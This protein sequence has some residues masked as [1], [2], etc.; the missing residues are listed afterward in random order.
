[1]AARKRKPPVAS[2]STESRV[3][4]SFGG[5]SVARIQL[6]KRM[7]D[8][9]D[10]T[11]AADLWER[12]LG[13]ERALGPIQSL[14]GIASVGMSFET[15]VVGGDAADDQLVSALERD[16]WAIFPED[17]QGEIIRWAAGLGVAV[18]HRDTWEEDPET[19]RLLPALDVWHARALR[20]DSDAS[21]WKISTREKPG[22]VTLTPG[23]SE[24]MLLTP[25]GK[26]RPWAKAP[27]FGL[28]LLWFA[29]QC[30]KVNLFEFN[31]TH[32]LPTRAAA[33]T[34]PDTHGLTDEAQKELA[35][36]VAALVRGGSIVLPDGYE[37][38]LL[39]ASAKNWEA[40]SKVCDEVWPKAVAIALTGN[41]LSTQVDGGSFAASKTAENV[42]YDRKRT[43]ARCLETTARDQMLTWWAEFNFAS[44]APPW[45]KYAIDPPRDLTA[46]ATRFQQGAQ[47]LA[48]LGSAGWEVEE[49]EEQKVAELLGVRVR[50]A[51]APA[52]LPAAASGDRSVATASLLHARAVAS[53]DGQALRD[54]KVVADAVVEQATA[55]AAKAIAPDLATLKRLIDDA[56][57]PRD[58]R[59]KLITAYGTMDPAAWAELTYRAE[60]LAAMAGRFSAAAE[61]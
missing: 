61:A 21:E 11:L 43:F 52:P 57:D 37:L 41:N 60:V 5:W 6:A 27:W 33:N 30:A 26:K 4:T 46:A 8:A 39:E 10:L 24:W 9:G 3:T 12:V 15:A 38:K 14:A 28:G 36:E 47:G 44:T 17:L 2:A 42:T 23:D 55:A 19:G 40:F 16:W 22:G 25:Y 18:V 59:T 1:M 32:A 34:K 56:T 45:P 31:D 48:T 20:W 51:V 35:D 50:R 29:A 54:G 13:D 53:D 7:A 49:G 58:L